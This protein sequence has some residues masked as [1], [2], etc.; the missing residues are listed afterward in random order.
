MS[1]EQQEQEQDK[2]QHYVD[3]IMN[4]YDQLEHAVDQLKKIANNSTSKEEL[5]HH[6]RD[7][8][9]EVKTAMKLQTIFKERTPDNIYQA[10]C[11]A[12]SI[13]E[14]SRAIQ[15]TFKPF[16][17]YTEDDH[18]DRKKTRHYLAAQC[19]VNSYYCMERAA[20][21]VVIG[22]IHGY[23]YAAVNQRKVLEWKQVITMAEEALRAFDGDDDSWEE[24]TTQL[25]AA[26]KLAQKYICD[27][28]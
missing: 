17:S 6:G 14:A 13:T 22:L 3:V 16:N 4:A 2:F 7:L 15:P 28:N 19:H 23:D 9:D 25:E 10:M 21:S 12:N 11:E 20:N 1:A 26:F 27:E 5:D 18:K 24:L 8:R